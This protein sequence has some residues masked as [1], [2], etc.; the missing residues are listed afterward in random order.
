MPQLE[1][2]DSIKPNTIKPPKK[3][4]GKL[5]EIVEIFFPVLPMTPPTKLK[6][7]YR[8]WP[9]IATRSGSVSLEESIWSC[10]MW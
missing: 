3:G 7:S 5:I 4:D 8:L 9:T 10:D 6:L 1:W 2:E